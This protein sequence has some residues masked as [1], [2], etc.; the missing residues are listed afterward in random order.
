MISGGLLVQNLL[1]SLLSNPVPEASAASSCLHV[2]LSCFDGTISD[3]GR[4]SASSKRPSD[5]LK[6]CAL[7]FSYQ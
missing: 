4:D 2:C 6:V 1:T 7:V 3:C 5:L